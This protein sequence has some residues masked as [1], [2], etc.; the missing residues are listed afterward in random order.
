VD[1][2]NYVPRHLDEFEITEITT[3]PGDED[4]KGEKDLD[5]DEM[6]CHPIHGFLSVYYTP[7][8]YQAEDE[9]M[10]DNIVLDSV[11]KSMEDNALVTYSTTAV[12]YVGVREILG[13][14]SVYL[15]ESESTS[16]KLKG[17]GWIV[18]GTFSCIMLFSFTFFCYKM[19]GLYQRSQCGHKAWIS[20]FSTVTK[21]GT[22]NNDADSFTTK[23]NALEKTIESSKPMAEVVADDATVMCEENGGRC[24]SEICY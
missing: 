9:E 11:K 13:F 16:S 18:L 23:D 6:T 10:I 5:A 21:N 19:R 20:K 7:S 22:E 14:N 12:H 8:G 2:E 24:L 4:A 15:D 1:G 17:S 3:A